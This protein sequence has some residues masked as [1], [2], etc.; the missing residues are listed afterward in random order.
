MFW[1]KKKRPSEQQERDSFRQNAQCELKAAGYLALFQEEQ[2]DAIQP[3]FAD[4]WLLRKAVTVSTPTLILEY[5]SGYSTYVLAKTLQELGG[6]RVISVE[7]GS[8]WREKSAARLTPDLARIVE[9]VSP[10]PSIRIVNAVLPGGSPEWF[11]KK[12]KQPRRLGI[13]TIMFQELHELAPDFVFL[14]GPDSA[15]VPGYLDS[16]TNEALAPVV[17][18]PLIFEKRKAPIICIDGRREQCAFLD[19]NLVSGYVTKIHEVQQF[20]FFYPHHSNQRHPAGK[21]RLPT[22]STR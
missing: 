7:L 17:S 12:S 19:A 2:S 4:L 16:A 1:K 9:F 22:G 6:G 14:D 18:D 21:H 15:Q 20:T 3:N 8:E 10:A 11:N 13:A 5:G